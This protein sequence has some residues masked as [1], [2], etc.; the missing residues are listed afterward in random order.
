M[1]QNVI[2][3]VDLKAR[4]VKVNDIAIFYKSLTHENNC[5]QKRYQSDIDMAFQNLVSMERKMET[6]L[7]Q[8][9]AEVAL[10]IVS[11]NRK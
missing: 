3:H 5:P 10:I 7:E 6:K 1:K 4:I 2:V 9:A 8:I 11:L